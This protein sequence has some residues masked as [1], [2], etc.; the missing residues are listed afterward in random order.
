MTTTPIGA[1]AQIEQA[2]SGF[3]AERDGY[4]LRLAEGRAV[5]GVLSPAPWRKAM[6]G[7]EAD[8]LAAT[9]LPEEIRRTRCM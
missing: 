6:E 2:L 7:T 4:E 5:L 1:V 3:K 8:M 9:K